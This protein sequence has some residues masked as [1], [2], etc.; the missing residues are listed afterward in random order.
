MFMIYLRVGH[1]PL[2]YFTG[3]VPIYTCDTYINYITSKLIS[4]KSYYNLFLAVSCNI[5]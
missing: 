4:Y 3:S 2:H 5:L 1:S